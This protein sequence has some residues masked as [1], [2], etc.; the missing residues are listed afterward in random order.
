LI[1]PLPLRHARKVCAAL[2]MDTAVLVDELAAEIG[3]TGVGH[4]L[5]QLNL[6]LETAQAG[7]VVAL[8]GVGQGC[9]VLLF[10][11]TDAIEGGRPAPALSAQI[12][13]GV[14]L[15]AYLKLPAFS[16]QLTLDRGLRAEADKRTALSVHARR[17]A[18]IN[19][20]LGT[21][22]TQCETPHF[23]RALLCVQC[24]SEQ[25]RDYGFAHRRAHVKTFTEDWQAYSPAPPLCY[26]NV[27]FE[28]G[29]NAFLTVTDVGPG[30]LE[31]G[32]ELVMAFRLKDVDPQ[33]GF[34]RYFF[35]GVPA[36]HYD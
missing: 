3:D 20:M 28:G 12:N 13:H 7:D 33:R 21:Q 5:L 25:M 19:S 29:G 18:E 15:D 14:A 23:P 9:D 31:V 8:V 27:A 1:L 17:R 35:K 6:T 16:G 4:A 2:N 24:G 32:T 30:E 22:C 26:G 10:R 34:R 36:R 11:V